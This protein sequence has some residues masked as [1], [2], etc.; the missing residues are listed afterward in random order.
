MVQYR[1]LKSVAAHCRGYEDDHGMDKQLLTPPQIIGVMALVALIV[2][3]LTFATNGGSILGGDT[4]YDG[5]PAVSTDQPVADGTHA[6]GQMHTQDAGTGEHVT[7]TVDHRAEPQQMHAQHADPY[8]GTGHGPM[9]EP[10]QTHD[11]YQTTPHHEEPYQEPHHQHG[12]GMTPEQEQQLAEEQLAAE[13]AADIHADPDQDALAMADDQVRLLVERMT[14]QDL[15]VMEALQQY[16]DDSIADVQ[17][18][19]DERFA[20]VDRVDELEADVAQL[21]EDV[22]GYDGDTTGNGTVVD[23]GGEPIVIDQDA[24]QQA[25]ENGEATFIHGD[26]ECHI[27]VH[28]A[29]GQ[30]STQLE[31]IR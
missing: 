29:D 10:V 9:V 8:S 16:V 4:A 28:T 23:S 25:L 6:N 2:I 3:P 7:H 11:T 1:G 17:M 15:A 20:S 27:S 18:W 21:Q 22:Y 12:Q 19:A 31:C 14:Q 24:Y 26:M 13:E 30:T 5:Q